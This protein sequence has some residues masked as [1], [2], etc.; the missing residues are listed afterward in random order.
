M[1][2]NV[3]TAPVYVLYFQLASFEIVST[4]FA[5]P[6]DPTVDV[7]HHVTCFVYDIA[8]VSTVKAIAVDTVPAM[9]AVASSALRSGCLTRAVPPSLV[10]APEFVASTDSSYQAI[11][12]S[13]I[14]VPYDIVWRCQCATHTGSTDS[15]M[16]PSR[17]SEAGKIISNWVTKPVISR[18]GALIASFNHSFSPP[19]V[20]EP[21]RTAP[22]GQT[23]SHLSSLPPFSSIIRAGSTRAS[24]VVIAPV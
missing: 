10:P 3:P 9:P 19:L 13:I 24:S 11:S 23:P 2:T 16:E 12:A 20:A 6:A 1:P 5:V 15:D 8:F 17:A 4:I 18:A 21:R 22:S 7:V 14:A